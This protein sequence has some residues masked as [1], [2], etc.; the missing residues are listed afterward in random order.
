MFASFS[1]PTLLWVSVSFVQ[2]LDA[3]EVSN[4]HEGREEGTLLFCVPVL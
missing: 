3:S 2:V 4:Y 1:P